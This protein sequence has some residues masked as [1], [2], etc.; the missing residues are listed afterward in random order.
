[1]SQVSPFGGRF[2][3]KSSLQ[4]TRQSMDEG[5]RLSV[6]QGSKALL[7][8]NFLNL[9]FILIPMMLPAMDLIASNLRYIM[10]N[11]VICTVFTWWRLGVPTRLIW[12]IRF[13]LALQ[14]WLTLCSF[15]SGSQLGRTNDF[16]TSN[17]FLIMAVIYYF[18]AAIISFVW[19][20]YR[21]WFFNTILFTFFLSCLVGFLQFLK[22]PPA[23]ALASFYNGNNDIT[24]WGV[25]EMG[26]IIH[27]AGSIRSIGLAS[28]P[29]WLAFQGMTGW[30]IVASRLLKRS[31]LPWEFIMATFFLLTAFTAQSRIM[32]LS[33]GICTIAFLYMLIR[34]DR[35]RGPLYLTVFLVGLLAMFG[36]FGER[37]SY[38][39]Q[40]NIGEDKTLQYRQDVGW[41]QAYQIMEERPWVGIGPDDGLVWSVARIVPDR[42]TQGQY[43]DNGFLLLLSWGGLPALA[44]YLPIV[45]I[46]IASAFLI[47]RNEDLSP[48]RRQAAFVGGVMIGMVLNN[49]LLNNGFTNIWMNCILACV[50][51]TALPNSSERLKEMQRKYHIH[52]GRK[53]K[54]A[55]YAQIPD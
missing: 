46:G 27:G 37:L 1:M 23:L 43:V 28:W 52:R 53:P 31:L 40:T 19:H 10:F 6:L 41:Q 8:W 7:Y 38:V 14:I 33:L 18:N 11:A 48:E 55:E 44:L 35:H 36:L 32:Y 24:A 4:L 16:E 5:K 17:Y 54:E 21:K 26:D 50:A 3:P 47:V 20:E 9:F 12:P 13:V 29:E 2:D 30:A 51:A 22:I 39:L 45:I 15:I 34:R 49:M 42:W 25:N